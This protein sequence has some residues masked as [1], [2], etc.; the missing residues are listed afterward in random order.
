MARKYNILHAFIMPFYS[1][2]FY[3]DVGQ[4]WRGTGFGFLFI[5]LLACWLPLTFVFINDG[6]EMV[7]SVVKP[8]LEKVPAM[9]VKEGILT[10][11]APM[12]YTIDGPN[13]GKPQVVID[14]SGKY[15]NVGQ[16]EAQV[17]VTKTNVSIK[18]NNDG[19][20]TYTFNK[21]TNLEVTQDKLHK[22]LEIGIKYLTMSFYPFAVIIS[23]LYRI[24]QVILYAVIGS[25]I[26]DLFVKSQLQYR[27]ILR[28]S[29][30]AVVP[31]IIIS[32]VLSI[33]GVAFPLELLFY[34]VLAMVYLMFGLSANKPT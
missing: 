26:L 13:T 2:Q 32:T 17:L 10:V 27:A 15:A 18:Q 1:K 4:S 29:V 12:P 20:K 14:T 23:F 16:T 25:L 30:M 19:I 7:D 22:W 21:S 28:L 33:V 8:Q 3:R 34:F 5:L 24:S 31:P 11:D 6:N 9:Q